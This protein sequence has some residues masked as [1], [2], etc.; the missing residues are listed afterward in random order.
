MRKRQDRGPKLRVVTVLLL[1]ALPLFGQKAEI[2]IAGNG[3][4]IVYVVN[5]TTEDIYAAAACY[6]G[7]VGVTIATL[8][9]SRSIKSDERAMVQR[10]TPQEQR[11]NPRAGPPE[12]CAVVRDSKV[13]ISTQRLADRITAY[14]TVHTKTEPM[15]ESVSARVTAPVP[16]HNEQQ[17]E[18]I[19]LLMKRVKITGYPFE[20]RRPERTTI[21]AQKLD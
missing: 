20:V 8:S 16:P 14:H 2:D 17:S 13:E 7:R 18:R 3:D 12:I 11:R 15:Q 1:C 19:L 10:R 21:P 6:P 5:D 4:E 9:L